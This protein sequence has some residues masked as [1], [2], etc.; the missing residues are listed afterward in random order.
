VEAARSNTK[1]LNKLGNSTKLVK[2][3]FGIIVYHTPT[4]EFNLETASTQVMEKIIEENNLVESGFYIKELA[5]LKQKDKVLGKF[6]SL[7]IWF[8]SMEGAEYLLNN[9]LLVG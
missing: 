5:W 3:W 2:P 8:N 6:A 1:W 9:G 7:G 4:K